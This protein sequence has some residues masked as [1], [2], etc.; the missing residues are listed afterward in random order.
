MQHLSYTL[1]PK[2]A[3]NLAIEATYWGD[4][5]DRTFDVLVNGVVVKTVK[6]DGSHGG[7]FF[8]ETYPIPSEALAV[9]CDGK[10]RVTFAATNG[11][12]AGGL[13]DLRLMKAE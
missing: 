3:K 8:S 13:F 10:L 4:D 11:G 12:L 2:G 7:N 1:D 5:R 9:R 6:L